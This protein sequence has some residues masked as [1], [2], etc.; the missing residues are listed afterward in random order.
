[1]GTELQVLLALL[2]GMLG[3]YSHYREWPIEITTLWPFFLLGSFSFGIE[4][5]LDFLSVDH[6]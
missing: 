4:F 6:A 1:M 5:L 3:A 2:V